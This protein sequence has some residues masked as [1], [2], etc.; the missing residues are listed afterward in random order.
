M[1]SKSPNRY[2]NNYVYTPTQKLYEDLVIEAIRMHGFW[3]HYLPRTSVNIDDL[4]GESSVNSFDDAIQ[5]EAYFNQAEGFEGNRMMT[6]MGPQFQEDVTFTIAQRRFEETRAEH[7]IG[8]TNESLEQELSSIYKANQFNGIL[9]EE[10]NIEGY[11]VPYSRPR[12]EDL[13]WVPLMQRMFVIK[14]VQH[15]AIFYQGGGLPTFELVCELFSYSQEKL[16]TGDPAIDSLE[17]LFSSD[18]LREPIAD[19]DNETINLDGEDGIMV[20]ES[21]NPEKADK[22]ADN[23]R[24]RKEADGVVDF[25]E[26]SPFVK[27]N[28]A[29][30]W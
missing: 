30:K 19:E 23:E 8:E 15:D 17:E 26:K 14:F 3:V 27:R 20:D 4:F 1:V 21:I 13:I 5:F 25:S 18:I 2:V 28:T 22:Q 6:E 12:E 24:F 10:G 16:D 29:M 7:L 9:L 11:Y